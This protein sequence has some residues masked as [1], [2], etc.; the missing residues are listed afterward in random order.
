MSGVIQGDG[1]VFGAEELKPDELV[2]VSINSSPSL[3]VP[4]NPTDILK[5]YIYDLAKFLEFKGVAGYDP[6]SINS[7]VPYL[8]FSTGMS[9]IADPIPRDVYFQLIGNE[10]RPLAD[11]LASTDLGSSIGDPVDLL[12]TVTNPFG[13]LGANDLSFVKNYKALATGS[14]RAVIISDLNFLSLFLEGGDVY[15]AYL[16]HCGYRSPGLTNVNDHFSAIYMNVNTNTNPPRGPQIPVKAGWLPYYDSLATLSDFVKASGE[17]VISGFVEDIGNLKDEL[18]N[19]QNKTSPD[20]I[21]AIL[22]NRMKRE[23][24]ALIKT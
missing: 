23:N 7:L 14:Y 1:V 3:G 16:R 9:L 21:F 13:S 2:P 19:P 15:R 17:K 4:I 8:R 18:N 6:Q 5:Q 11:L 10:N 22:Y 24:A 20:T 12:A